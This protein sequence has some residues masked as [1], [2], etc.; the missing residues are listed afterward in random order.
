MKI[1]I[2]CNINEQQFMESLLNM[3]HSKCDISNIMF[4]FAFY[5]FAKGWHIDK[6]M[7]YKDLLEEEN[8]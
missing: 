6:L 3:K 1:K 8:E 5:A 2:K 4:K 7:Y